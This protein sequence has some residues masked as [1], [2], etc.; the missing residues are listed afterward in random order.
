MRA[1]LFTASPWSLAGGVVYTALLVFACASDVRSRRIPNRLAAPLAATGLMYSAATAASPGHGVLYGFAGLALGLALWVPFYSLRWL[2]AGDVKLF[3]AA[4][5]WL[6]PVRTL[7][8]ALIAAFA[9]GVLAVVWMLR[10]YG[11]AGTMATASLALSSP[12]TAVN[13]PVDVKSRRAIPYGVALAIG[14]ATAAW[15]PDVVIRVFNA[16][17]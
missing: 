17:Y 8:G 5:A 13:H 15:F 6:G 16:A 11:V 10:A 3:A 4:G 14:A 12:R 1:S 9:G 7:E 2:G